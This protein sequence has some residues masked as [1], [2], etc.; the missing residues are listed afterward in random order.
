VTYNNNSS[1]VS[2]NFAPSWR[3]WHSSVRQSAPRARLWL[4]AAGRLI[5]Q[6]S[7]ATLVKRNLAR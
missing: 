7:R 1:I 6:A 3:T 2:F 5:Y 4:T